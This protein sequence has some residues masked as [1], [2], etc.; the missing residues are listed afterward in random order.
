[1]IVVSAASVGLCA[2]PSKES[3]AALNGRWASV[4]AVKGG[5]AYPDK[6]RKSI[7]LVLM[8]GKY[9]ATVGG[10]VDEGT[11]KIDDSANPK[12]ITFVV[13]KGP[14]QGKTIQGIYELDKRSLKICSDLSGKTRP[15]RF[16]SKPD[17]QSFLASYHLQARKMR[18]QPQGAGKDL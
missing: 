11:F 8:N 3:L 16:E 5:E 4:S 1:M 18:L 10:D 9:T 7:H 2:D 12:T 13:T 17:T 14:N 6:I 15:T